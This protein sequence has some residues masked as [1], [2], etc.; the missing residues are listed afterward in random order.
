MVVAGVW[1]RVRLADRPRGLARD[2]P[3]RRLRARR[4][5]RVVA[6][7]PGEAAVVSFSYS[8]DLELAAKVVASL[9]TVEPQLAEVVVDLRWRVAR[10]H[11]T[12][13]GTAAAAHL[14][15]TS[16]GSA[17]YAEMHEALV[18]MR[19]ADAPPPSTT[20]RP[21]LPTP[22]CGV[23]SGD[24][25]RRR[26]RW[27]TPRRASSTATRARR[28]PTTPC[29]GGC[30]TAAAMAGDASIAEEFASAYD[31]A[32]A[33]C[34]AAVGDLVDAFTHLRPAHRS[35]PGQP[36]P[37]REPLPHLRPHRLHRHS[38]RGR[39]RLGP[40]LLA[41]LLPRWR[42]LRAALVGVVDPRP[43][44]GL[45][46]AGRR[47]RPAARGRLGLA[48][49]LVPGRR[50]LGVLLL[51]DPLVL[52]CS[53]PPRSRSPSRSPPAW[54]TAAAPS[55]T[56]APSWPGPATRTPTT[57]T[58]Q[59]AAILDLVH[60]LLRDAVI[61]EG[62]GIVLG[63]L[64][65]GA[66]AAGATA[67]NAAR[68]A[69]AAPRLLRI[70]STLRT[71]AST[72]AAPL[73]FAATALRDVRRELAVFRRAR[74][75][76][77]SAYKAERVA[78]VERLRGL[79]RNP[80]LFDPKELRGLS[81]TESS[82]C[83]RVGR[84]ATARRG[85]GSRACRPAAQWAVRSGSWTAIHR[86]RGP[87]PITEGSLRG[88]VSGE[89]PADQ[90]SATRGIQSC[91]RRDRRPPPRRDGGVL[92]RLRATV[93][94]T[95]L[96]WDLN[97]GRRGLT[98]TRSRALPAGIRRD[99]S[100]HSTKVV[101]AAGHSS[102]SRPRPSNPA[103]PSTSTWTPTGPIDSPMQVWCRIGREQVAV[104]PDHQSALGNRQARRRTD[105][106]VTGRCHGLDRVPRSGPRPG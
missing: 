80:R 44:R 50:P 71:L 9:S 25:H 45:R 36:R 43:G 22:R 99:H 32:A 3:D 33:S 31:D 52:R 65:A 41:P 67:L 51:G 2:V 73:R 55:V 88:R 20:P 82:R 10:L 47:H 78:R 57:S 59:R 11:E 21:P 104:Q 35:L 66:T 101:W 83:A 63:T 26:P 85:E 29:A 81:K 56:S 12:W 48:R 7:A 79:L 102:S 76:V 46:L 86:A 58:R 106:A 64:T 90:D 98:E 37:R 70:I 62:I 53:A 100:R 19:A 4:L 38:L 91:D 42:P 24:A 54:P 49:R 6:G 97:D 96:G 75:T 61:I 95:V 1:R 72:C 74:I 105:V 17:S 77:A 8:V 28:W 5:R 68:I 16:R 39:L 27:S 93:R 103:R 23:R 15:R 13:A 14:R 84:C 30:R 69:A 87:I 94:S 60:D 34:L 40:P 89:R 92:R 18:A